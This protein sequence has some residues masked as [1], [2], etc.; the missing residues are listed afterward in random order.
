MAIRETPKTTAEKPKTI[1][2][3]QV[4]ELE[5]SAV[6]E[7][8]DSE[9]EGGEADD[10]EDDAAEDEADEIDEVVV[11]GADPKAPEEIHEAKVTRSAV[12][13]D[14]PKE[15][16]KVERVPFDPDKDA[17]PSDYVLEAPHPFGIWIGG[18]LVQFKKGKTRLTTGQFAAVKKHTYVSDN[19][20][21]ILKMKR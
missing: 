14:I 11:Q 18:H 20:A 15:A 13:S 1:N 2:E 16:P 9:A 5:A 7:A 6:D 10:F 17:E 21:S 3:A 19:G 8:E 4:D 12:A